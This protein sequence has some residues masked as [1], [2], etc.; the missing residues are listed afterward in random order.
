[1]RTF[2]I[3]VLAIAA[4]KGAFAQGAEPE[5][6][7][8]DAESVAEEPAP[9]PSEAMA[10]GDS[11]ALMQMSL[12]ELL[13]IV[14][15]TATRTE[16]TVDE[17]PG[18][19][20][21]VTRQQI[22]DLNA[23]S[24]REVLNV[25][26]AGF[27]VVPADF[28]YGDRVNEGIFVRGVRSD[29]LQNVLILWNG[30]AKFNETTFAGSFT[31]GEQPPENIDHLE[32]SRSPI[33]LYGGAGFTVVNIIT[34]EQSM[35][36]AEISARTGV[37]EHS[38]LR[39]R[40]VLSKR[41]TGIMGKTLNNWH[42]SG[43][44]QLFTDDG[45]AQ[46]NPAGRGGYLYPADTMRDGTFFAH[47]LTLS[48]RTK[49]DRFAIQTWY[50]HTR[51][52][53]FLSGLVPSAS[54]DL[55][56][57]WAPAWLTL[58][59]YSPTPGLVLSV[60]N[61]FLGWGQSYDLSGTPAGGNENNSDTYVEALYTQKLETSVGTHE[62]LW[63]AKVENEGQ[64][65]TEAYKWNG[66]A[67]LS[68]QD[69]NVIWVPNAYR[70][71]YSMFAEDTW[72]IAAPVTFTLG[73]RADYYNGFGERREFAFNPRAAIVTHF[74]DHLLTLKALYASAIRPPAIYER[75]G[76]NL[77]PLV[78]N[79]N[80]GPEQLQTMEVSAILRS[81]GFKAQITPFFS[82]L[83]H[84]IAYVSTGP[85]TTAQ[86]TGQTRVLGFDLDVRHYFSERTYAF[87]NGS[88]MRSYIVATNEDTTFLPRTY[89][90]AGANWNW[91]DLNVNGSVY[92]RSKRP[93]GAEQE[94]NE[95]HTAAVIMPNLSISY[96]ILEQLR[97]YVNVEN[98]ISRENEIPL[99]A[100]EFLYPLRERTYHVGLTG[101]I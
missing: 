99:F 55:Y 1:M 83:N 4:S 24:L 82:I 33:P 22:D 40:G 57:W 51:Q 3:A 96:D 43:S 61:S 79:S 73:G 53:S 35:E 21:V 7:V 37:N 44:V 56:A 64:Y 8:G 100:D 67:L 59:R 48:L 70:Q 31:L 26:V 63:G 25:Y 85:V 78:G 34:R 9:Q 10:G 76:K 58:V 19:I 101:K 97:L 16:Q 29:V 84:R 30:E 28:A 15:T 88:I 23:R 39:A 77:A 75:L 32:I 68:S 93:L 11:N 38:N 86:N 98:V 90:N 50:K 81:G 95:A 54:N 74:L 13:N 52:H 5:V 47:N 69:P 41:V 12:D 87:F 6:A 62:V 65:Y 45:Q 72:R 91:H 49:D 18:S 60:G 89:V 94:S 14:V 17:A 27:D 2:C 20:T 42:L 92:C 46:Y 66:R 80:I 36:G 71:V